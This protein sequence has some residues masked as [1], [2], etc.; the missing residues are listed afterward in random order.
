MVASVH[1][2]TSLGHRRLVPGGH[3][4]S[5]WAAALGLLVWRAAASCGDRRP[6]GAGQPRVGLP[7]STTCSSWRSPSRCC[8]GR[9][10]RCGRGGR[11]RA[12]TISVGAP[13]FNRV[14]GADLRGAALPDG[15]RAGAALGRRLVDDDPRAV[16]G[17]APG[18]RSAVASVAWSLGRPRAGAAR[19]SWP[20]PLRGGDD[21]RRGG[22]RRPLPGQRPRRGAADGRLA[23]GDAQPA[24]IRGLPRPRS[25]I[26]V[27]AVAIAVSSRPRQSTRSRPCAPGETADASAPTG[28]RHERLVVEPLAADARVIE[29]RAELT[30]RRAR[31][32]GSLA[33]RAAR[34]SELADADRHAGGAHARSARTSTSRSSRTTRRPAR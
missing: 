28:S 32:P 1:S 23:A 13:W 18:R 9:S 21:G 24:P 16:R 29:T 15:R 19:R 7:A 2:F 27:M 17:A 8:S 30:L 3:R 6:P 10:T 33:H 31:S 20:G 5:P 34:L 12:Q 26:C 14:D 4:S 22:A 25:A 11:Q